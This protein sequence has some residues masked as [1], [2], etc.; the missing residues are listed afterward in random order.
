MKAT[1]DVLKGAFGEKFVPDLEVVY[2]FSSS[3]VQTIL[4]VLRILPGA[5]NPSW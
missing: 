4:W 1:A 2:N 5:D 3:A